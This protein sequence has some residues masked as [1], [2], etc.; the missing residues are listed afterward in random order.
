MQP[1]EA[2]RAGEHG[3]G[4]AVVADEVRKLAEQVSESLSEITNV[5]NTIQKESDQVTV[6]L[7]EG[8]GEVS[9]GSEQMTKT[10]DTF[11][12]IYDAVNAM[13][14]NISTVK[15]HVDRVNENS[16]EMNGS[17]GEIAAIS[18]ESA[19]GIEQTSAA[20]Q[21]TSSSMEQV[22]ANAEQLSGLANELTTLIKRFSL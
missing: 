1:I 3:K 7:Q 19:A 4:F 2:A 5:V 8:Y 20:T 9:A 12:T 22:T 15:S 21:Q 17:V 6:A 14:D 10:K 13:T 18:E 11:K 16:K